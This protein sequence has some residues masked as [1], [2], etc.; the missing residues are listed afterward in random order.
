MTRNKK[1]RFRQAAVTALFGGLITASCVTEP[2][3]FGAVSDHTFASYYAWR[4]YAPDGTFIDSDVYG[5]KS[6]G[7]WWIKDREVCV[8]FNFNRSSTL[9]ARPDLSKFKPGKADL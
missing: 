1:V 6:S 7:T 8:L 4:Y 2:D 9:C 3:L 5:K